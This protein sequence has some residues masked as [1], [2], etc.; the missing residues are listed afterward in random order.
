[1][2]K[3]KTHK[4]PVKSG[5]ALF[6]SLNRKGSRDDKSPPPALRAPADPAVCVKCGAVYTRKKWHSPTAGIAP[7]HRART[8]CPACLQVAA[9]QSFGQVIVRDV[10]GDE[11]AMRQRIS[12]VAATAIRTQPERRVVAIERRGAD[13]EVRTTSQKLAHRIARELEKAFQGHAEYHWSDEDGALLSIWRRVEAR[14][15]VAGSARR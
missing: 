11:E 9:S 2:T 10:G 14:R 12:N 1:M 13:L 6:R 15:P 8:V 5:K 4:A 7:A 3:V